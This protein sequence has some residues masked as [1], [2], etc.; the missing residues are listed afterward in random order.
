MHI[1]VEE[2]VDVEVGRNF[3]HLYLETF[4]PL[5]ILAANKH[6]YEPEVWDDEMQDQRILK[7]VAWDQER[8]VGLATVATDLDAVPWVSPDYYRWRYPGQ[9]IWYCGFAIVHPDYQGRSLFSAL[10]RTSLAE[11]MRNDAIGAFDC[12]KVT[13]EQ[14]QMVSKLGRILDG[15][16]EYELECADVQQYWMVHP[17]VP[18][19]DLDTVAL[20]PSQTAEL[21]DVSEDQRSGER[22]PG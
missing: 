16:C 22:V 18:K 8:A 3:Y 11:M 7:F 14:G 13:E 21:P 6:I 1:S 5:A 4:G 19:L 12:A 9:K 20:S 17:G 15:L 2:R 10:M